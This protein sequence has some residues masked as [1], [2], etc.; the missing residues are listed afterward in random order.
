MGQGYH[1]GARALQNRFDTVRLADRLDSVAGDVIGDEFRRFIEERDMFFLATADA[2]G[3]PECSYKGGAP[4]FVRVV[5]E[6][7]IAFPSY[8]GNGM[9]LSLGN[10][11]VNP[12]VG[13]LFINF[14]DG[15]RLRLNGVATVDEDDPLMAEYPGA[16][17]IVRVRCEKVFPNCRRYVHRQELV[18]PSPFVPSGVEDPPVPDWKREPW[19]D[20]TLPEHDPAHDPDRPSAPSLP[21]F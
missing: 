14:T 19:F 11:T 7:T 15:T 20:G 6:H 13:L 3:R 1:E 8:D 5:D 10:V 9:F 16:L 17:L 4:G 12:H 18:A 2:E 21:Q